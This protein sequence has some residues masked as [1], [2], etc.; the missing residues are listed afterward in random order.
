MTAR[1]SLKQLLRLRDLSHL[2]DRDPRKT[3]IDRYLHQVRALGD[4]EIWSVTSSAAARCS[5]GW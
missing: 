2:N 1:L 3:S 4:A 5:I